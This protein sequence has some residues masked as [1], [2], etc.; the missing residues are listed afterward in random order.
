MYAH[1]ANIYIPLGDDSAHWFL[2]NPVYKTADIVSWKIVHTLQRESGALSSANIPEELYRRGYVTE[3]PVS[4]AEVYPTIPDESSSNILIS[5]A[6]TY[7]CNLRCTYCFQNHTSSQHSHRFDSEKISLLSQAIDILKRK[8]VV[9]SPSHIH[10]ELT[11]GEPLLPANRS[12]VEGLL[13]VAGHASPIFI[14][15]NG[16]SI[17]EYTA[18]LS[19]YPVRLRIT[20]DGIPAV[21]DTRRISASGQGTC[22]KIIEGIESAREAGIPI[23]VKINLDP[24]NL[25]LLDKGFEMM[26]RY[27]WIDDPDVS[28]GLARVRATP[29]YDSVWTESAFVTH[30]CSYLEEHHL[31][32]YVD[33]LFT[34]SRYFKDIIEGKEPKVRIRRCRIDK[35]FFFNPDGLIF[36]C[37]LLESYPVGTFYP[38]FSLDEGKMISL[39]N[40]VITTLSQCRQCRYALICGGGCPADS[41]ERYGTLFRHACIDYPHILKN[42]IPYLLKSLKNKCYSR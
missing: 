31:Q 33:V 36:P 9:F 40:R 28:L 26:E 8:Y 34:G 29:T 27:G 2:T 24:Q 13:E 39:K 21:H 42:Y 25:T 37:I 5:V 35:N 1:P 38:S 18:L 6:V 12:A 7:E 16:T 22:Q 10:W 17:P 30:I 4:L 32:K 3:P 41:L 15:T 19:S 20:L 11:G 23:T 14:T